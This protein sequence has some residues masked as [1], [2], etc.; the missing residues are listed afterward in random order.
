MSFKGKKIRLTAG[1]LTVAVLAMNIFLVSAQ[2]AGNFTFDMKA[3]NVSSGQT[4]FQ[5][6][7]S[8]RAGDRVQFQ[9]TIQGGSADLNNVVVR[10]ALPS[11]LI[12]STGEAGLVSATGFNKP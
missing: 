4:A 6:S 11:R 12:F 7:V 9:L 10:S 1:I 2:D 5:D 8:A 3:R